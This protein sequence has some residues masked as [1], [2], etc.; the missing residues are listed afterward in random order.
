MPH[1]FLTSQRY[2]SVDPRRTSWIIFTHGGGRLGNQLVSFAHLL[3]FLIEHPGAFSLTNIA[4][5]PYSSLVHWT[6]VRPDCSYPRSKGIPRVVRWGRDLVGRIRSSPHGGAVDRKLV[7]NVHALSESTQLAYSLIAGDIHQRPGVIGERLPSLNLDTDDAFDQLQQAPAVILAGWHI[8]GWQ[9]LEKH[10][11]EV[12]Q[13]LAFHPRYVT[14]ATNFIESLRLRYR[15]L[16]GVLIRQDDYRRVRGGKHFFTTQQYAAWMRQA[17]EAFGPDVAFVVASDEEQSRDAFQ[18]LDVHFATGQ[19]VGP[20]HYVENLIELSL[21]DIIMTPASTFS[22]WAAFM[23]DVPLLPL[24]D[25]QQ[26]VGEGDLLLRH[27]FDAK[28]H[29]AL[30]IST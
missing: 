21:C 22:T 4:F 27:L 6:S 8:R 1:T 15:K 14:P 24:F 2:Y 12:R 7:R 16:I 3:A 30:S 13:L 18:G 23:G 20:G 9:L 17:A 11:R 28:D 10:Q 26:D 25:A 5:W 29:P 19:A